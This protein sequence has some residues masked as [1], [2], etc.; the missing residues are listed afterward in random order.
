MLL[1][2]FQETQMEPL[3]WFL[4]PLLMTLLLEKWEPQQ[5]DL[6][7]QSQV[8]PAISFPGRHTAPCSLHLC[9]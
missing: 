1:C 7:V 3:R 4:V 9:L 5:P 2:T 8:Q 6:A